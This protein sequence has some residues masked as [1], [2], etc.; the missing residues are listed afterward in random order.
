MPSGIAREQHE[1]PAVKGEQ[2]SAAWNRA[3]SPAS[4]A[5]NFLRRFPRKRP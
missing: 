2:G 4:R 1:H 5:A 3:S